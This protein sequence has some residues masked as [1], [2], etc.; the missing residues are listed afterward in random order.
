MTRQ[1]NPVDLRAWQSAIASLASPAA[2]ELVDALGERG[3]KRRYVEISASAGAV[4]HM[5]HLAGARAPFRTGLQH[6]VDA[7]LDPAHRW[8]LRWMLGR[9]PRGMITAS[10]PLGAATAEVELGIL[11][12]LTP[13]RIALSEGPL[14]F[15]AESVVHFRDVHDATAAM[16]LTGCRV[17]CYGGGPTALAGR[18][19][20]AH[21]NM[22]AVAGCMNLGAIARDL[23]VPVLHDLAGDAPD[24]GAP[25]VELRWSPE[26]GDSLSVEVGPVP[27]ARLLGLVRAAVGEDEAGAVRAL[28]QTFKQPVAARARLTFDASGLRSAGAL[29]APRGQPDGAW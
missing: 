17:I 1:E 11:A 20:V 3:V 18:W 6:L 23:V 4:R 15:A 2:Q 7:G 25:V 8:M 21:S 29:F 19:P 22:V 24:G 16:G 12:P 5:A 28:A 14:P 26:P 13:T 27:T 10:V 9:W